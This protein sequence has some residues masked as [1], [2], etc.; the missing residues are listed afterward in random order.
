MMER[1]LS[2]LK[3]LEF[4]NLVT[5]PY[6]VKLLADLG[7]QV[8]KIENP[9][10]GDKAR[11]RGPFA[12]DNPGL[13]KSGL[14]AYLNTNKRSI[15]LNPR[16]SLGKAVFEDLIKDADILVENQ[17]PQ[18]ME[19]LGLTYDALEKIN[20]QLIMTSI[21][22]FGQTGPHRDYKAHELTTYNGCGYGFIS[23]V[24]I[25]EP[26]MPPVKAGGRQ[27]EFGAAQAAA[28]ATM[29]AVHARDQ[30]DAGQHID[31]S[32]QEVMAG[33]YESTIQHWVLAE[34][35]MGGLTNPIIQPMLPLECKDGWIFLMCVEE[36]Q[37]D[38]LVE[39][40]GNPE[41]AQTELFQDRF[42]RA[43]FADALVPLL[44]EWTMQYAKDE[45]FKMCQAAR[46]P[47]GPAYSSEEVVCSEHLAARNYF[48]E[49]DHPEIGQAKY[50]GAPYR[51][52]ATPW[53]IERVAPVLGEHNEEILCDRLGYTMEDLVH[54]KQAGVI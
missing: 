51:L 36:D 41:W 15:T 22:P 52:S 54:M 42:L 5:A 14:F 18:L 16:T 27:S 10:G 43:D 32:I 4:G 1:A 53:Q 46:V 48:V 50:P 30:I 35:E 39:V 28:V 37:F 26:V 29:C 6:C 19:E 7:A 9:V 13:E 8:I 44:T 45:L 33:Q 49:M 3:V 23:T 38:R 40:M 24:C 25:T 17:P 2:D 12:G 20:S 34:N 31:I 11:S 21:T 47:V